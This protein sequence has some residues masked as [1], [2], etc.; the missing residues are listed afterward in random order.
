MGACVMARNRGSVSWSSRSGSPRS[1]RLAPGVRAVVKHRVSIVFG[2]H[3]TA[4]QLGGVKCEVEGEYVDAGF[5]D[6]A[7]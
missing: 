2:R 6:H 5:A 4:L 1:S 3:A 7:E